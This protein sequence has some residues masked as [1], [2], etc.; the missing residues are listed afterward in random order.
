MW[1]TLYNGRNGVGIVVHQRFRD[2]VAEVQRFDNR[3]MKV[4]VTTT[5]QRLHFFSA[6][7]AYS[8]IDFI[9]VR[10]RDQKLVTDAKVVPYEIVATQHRPLICT[11]KVMSPK[12]M[13]DE[14]SG[15]ARIKWWRLKEKEETVTFRVELPR[16]PSGLCELSVDTSAV[17]QHQ[18]IRTHYR[19][20]SVVS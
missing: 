20:I 19:R 13:H 8:A 11:M 10:Y 14:R 1:T 2:S 6:W 18:D 9:L 16:Q 12:R 17:L 4:V 3:L 7:R 5:E 15:P